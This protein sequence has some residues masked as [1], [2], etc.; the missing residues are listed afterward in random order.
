MKI[1]D[2]VTERSET[3]GRNMTGVVVYIHPKGRY[4]TVEF[5]NGKERFRENFMGPGRRENR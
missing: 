3:V 2:K 1:E 5:Q 4:N